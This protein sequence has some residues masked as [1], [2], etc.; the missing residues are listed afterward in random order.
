VTSRG[1][2]GA[3]D[4][5]GAADGLRG[6][7][8]PRGADR[9]GAAD[10]LGDAD[11]PRGA[12]RVGAADGLGDADGPSGA[13]GV[14]APDALVVIGRITSA[15][16]IR[17]EVKVAPDTDDPERFALLDHVWLL[18]PD[19]AP[20]GA[21]RKVATRGARLHAGRV[22]LSLD[23]VND[24]TSAE[25]LRGTLVAIDQRE[26]VALPEGAFFV[27]DIIGMRVC[28]ESG[29]EL[30]TVSAVMA[31]GGRDVYVVSKPGGGEWLLPAA[32]EFITEVDTATGRMTVAPPEGLDEATGT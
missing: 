16:G 12:D 30:G 8:D 14:G 18:P 6:A 29:R 7:D 31:G 17:G 28:D 3:S 1:P 15:H 24:R 4:G 9:V 22:L 5:A 10:G 13:D 27:D 26:R 23:G 25:R 21:P 11:G 2:E 20:D 19:G 32:A